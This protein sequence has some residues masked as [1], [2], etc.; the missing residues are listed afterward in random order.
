VLRVYARKHLL[1]R[2]VAQRS[3]ITEPE[4]TVAGYSTGCYHEWRC[5][6]YVQL[7]TKAEPPGVK[8]ASAA[9]CP[10]SAYT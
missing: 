3:G 6:Q 9:Q 8:A 5:V 10:C 2:Q 1:V 7:E 4:R